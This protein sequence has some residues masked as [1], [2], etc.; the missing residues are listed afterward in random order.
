M[1]IELLRNIKLRGI[2]GK[3]MTKGL[4]NDSDKEFPD[5]IYEEVDKIEKGKN[6]KAIRVIE[7]DR[8]RKKTVAP[9]PKKEE[10]AEMEEDLTTLDEGDEVVDTAEVPSEEEEEEEKSSSKKKKRKRA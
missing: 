6:S 2:N 10:E 1:V 4:Y 9:A 5:V 3:V 8:K 7:S